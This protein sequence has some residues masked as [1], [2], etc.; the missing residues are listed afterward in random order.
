[1]AAAHGISTKRCGGVQINIAILLHSLNRALG[2]RNS[3]AKCH[4]R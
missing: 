4:N 2:N 1:V 3:M